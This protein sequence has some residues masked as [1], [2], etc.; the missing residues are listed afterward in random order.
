M[1][2]YC[3]AVVPIPKTVKEARMVRKIRLIAVKV[4]KPYSEGFSPFSSGN[5]VD[6]YRF[7]QNHVVRLA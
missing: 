1:F 3:S 2:G 6:V 7:G 4:V 5:S